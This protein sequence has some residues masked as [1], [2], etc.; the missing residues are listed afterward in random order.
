MSYNFDDDDD[1][2][3]FKNFNKIFKEIQ[4][5]IFKMMENIDMDNL[6]NL[7]DG[8]PNIRQFGFSINMGPDGKLNV[9]PIGDM[10][11]IDPKE[12]EKI[13]KI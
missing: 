7:S 13:M 9:K 6:D 11:N 12:L 2:Q 1:N 5:K 8:E 10:G 4:E 3:P